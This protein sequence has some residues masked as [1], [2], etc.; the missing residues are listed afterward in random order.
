[1]LKIEVASSVPRNNKRQ[2]ALEKSDYTIIRNK[3]STKQS[4]ENS[5][6]SLV[7]IK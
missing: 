2:D 7:A 3:K 6:R 5:K 4:L 1:M